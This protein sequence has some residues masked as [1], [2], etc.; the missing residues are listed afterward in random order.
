MLKSPRFRIVLGN[1]SFGMGLVDHFTIRLPKVPSILR[2]LCEAPS[3][4]WPQHSKLEHRQ[5]MC[6]T[7]AVVWT[8]TVVGGG[9]ELLMG[10]DFLS[11]W[12]LACTW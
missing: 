4:L 2:I 9:I 10:L 3:P 12:C 7:V 6:N 5:Y 11:Y 1:Q 8:T